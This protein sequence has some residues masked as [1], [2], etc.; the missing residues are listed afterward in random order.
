MNDVWTEPGDVVPDRAQLRETAGRQREHGGR[1]PV[2]GVAGLGAIPPPGQD[3]VC[4]TR[5]VADVALESRGDAAAER[6]DNVEDSNRAARS[7]LCRRNDGR[8]QPCRPARTPPAGGPSAQGPRRPFEAWID[9]R[10]TGQWVVQAHILR[11]RT[12]DWK[13]TCGWLTVVLKTVGRPPQP[14]GDRSRAVAI[15]LKPP[16]GTSSRASSSIGGAIA[17]EAE[18]GLQWGGADHDGTARSSNSR[19]HPPWPDR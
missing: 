9:R 3:G 11:D 16:P 10:P 6:L 17:S 4:L 8:A 19:L 5:S 18:L 7:F 2:Q 1:Q 13:G 15:Q 12:R 14:L